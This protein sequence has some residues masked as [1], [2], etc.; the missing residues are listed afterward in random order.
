MK[1][2]LAVLSSLVP[3]GLFVYFASFIGEVASGAVIRESIAWVP[4]LGINLDFTL[5]GLSLLFTLLITGIGFLVFL[6]SSAYLKG[7]PYL[8]RFYGYLGI[9]MGAMLGLVLSDNLL[10]MFLFWELTSISSFFLI[11]FRN[12]LSVLLGWAFAY[13]RDTPQARVIVNPPGTKPR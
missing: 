8:D 6:Y 13:I 3:L 7:D 9:F 2:K 1:G 11:G 12:R 4:S 10:S 5:D